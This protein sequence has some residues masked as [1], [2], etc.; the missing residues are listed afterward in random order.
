MTNME[1]RAAHWNERY[2][3]VGAEHV[4]W[5]EPE[6]NQSLALVQ[7]AAADHNAS[8]IDIGGGASSLAGCLVERGYSDVSVLDVSTE[9]LDAAKAQLPRPEAVTWIQA[10]LL[11]WTPNRRWQ[12]WHDR[13]V[14]HFLTDQRDRA[15]YRSLLRRAIEPGGAAI[16]ATFGQDGPTSCSGLP[17]ARYSAEALAAE[18]G[19]GFTMIRSGGYD[20][21][22]PAGVTQKFSWVV[23]RADGKAP[24]PK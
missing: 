2:R 24:T 3:S 1:A 21:H 4:S 11:E 14:F 7:L 13:A 10:D 18:V 22:T 6:P 20:H 5:F 23:L 15:T 17:V 12:I 8:V 16:I 19:P 9:A